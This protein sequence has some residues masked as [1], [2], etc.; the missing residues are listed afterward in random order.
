MFGYNAEYFA[1]VTEDEDWGEEILPPCKH[2]FGGNTMKEGL[3]AILIFCA[4]SLGVLF[5]FYALG[6]REETERNI[7]CLPGKVETYYTKNNDKFVVC[8]DNRILKQ[9]NSKQ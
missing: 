6:T 1:E 9:I 5:G 3:I 8:S 2:Q 4:F 7:T